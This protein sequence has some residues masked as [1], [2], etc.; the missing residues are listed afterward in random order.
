[1]AHDSWLMAHV[2][3]L[4][5]HGSLIMAHGSWCMAHGY[6]S[7]LWLMDHG[8]GYGSWRMVTAL[9]NG[10][11]HLFSYSFAYSLLYLFAYS[12]SYSHYYYLQLLLLALARLF[13]LALALAWHSRLGT[14]SLSLGFLARNLLSFPRYLVPALT[15]FSL[16][17]LGSASLCFSALS[18]W[19]LLFRT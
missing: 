10:M 2:S 8:H 17:S 14:R 19:P 1:M 15:L 4:I 9:A 3:C 7:W 12:L 18:A 6:G 5:A 13:G 16:V 11:A